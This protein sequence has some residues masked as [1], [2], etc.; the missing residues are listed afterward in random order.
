M[1]STSPSRTRTRISPS[2]ALSN[3]AIGQA[4]ELAEEA[5]G[6]AN[7]ANQVRIIM[8]CHRVIGSSGALTGFGGGLKWNGRPLATESS[9]RTGL[10][11]LP[12]RA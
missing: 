12:Q 8:P 5:V 10:L 7:G 9:G 3:A 11:W 1:C 6:A 4:L 2:S